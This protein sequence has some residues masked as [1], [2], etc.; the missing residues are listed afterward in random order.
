MAA[1]DS[2]KKRQGSVSTGGT[3]WSAL[4]EQIRR[5]SSAPPAG[6]GVIPDP[7][8]VRPRPPTEQRRSTP[9]PRVFGKTLPPPA[10]ERKTAE[11]ADAAVTVRTTIP[12]RPTSL[13]EPAVEPKHEASAKREASVPATT[14]QTVSEPPKLPADQGSQGTPS[15]VQEAVQSTRPR[16]ET[17]RE[18]RATTP[19]RP[20]RFESKVGYGVLP[21]LKA[22]ATAGGG[23]EAV[24]DLVA[25]EKVASVKSTATPRRVVD[26]SRADTPRQ[27][28]IPRIARRA[29]DQG[30]NTPVSSPTGARRRSSIPPGSLTGAAGGG[31]QGGL[32]TVVVDPSLAQDAAPHS[33]SV[34]GRSS[35]PS[36][37]SVVVD[38]SLHDDVKASKPSATRSSVAVAK[39]S[40]SQSTVQ[41]RKPH[42]ESHDIALGSWD[43]RRD[44]A[45]KAAL[46]A[47]ALLVGVVLYWLR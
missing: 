18:R 26:R 6:S 20:R 29:P 38:S 36:L 5:T 11:A 9:P 46:V 47:G 28:A 37:P 23:R 42:Q 45:T 16:L 22:N 7:S 43:R 14:A 24:R 13:K 4:R 17:P 39:D 10:T 31:A 8:G 40:S 32:P 41:R 21:S 44:V 25:E 34:G 19:R 35:N 33:G 12:E 3:S 15:Q 2:A 30:D 27:R 1:D